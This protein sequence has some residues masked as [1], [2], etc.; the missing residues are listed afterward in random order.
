M[1]PAFSL[2]P[3][4]LGAAALLAGCAT[5]PVGPDY[6]PPE[7]LQPAHAAS[8]GAFASAEAQ[9]ASSATPLPPQWWRLYDDARLD[10]LIEQAFAHNTDLRQAVAN[11]EREQAVDQ[12]VRGAQKP[13]VT[14]GGGPSFGHKSGLDLVKPGYE[15]PSTM[16]YGA[17]ASLSYQL[18][19][20]GQIRRAIEAAE[21]GTGSAEAAVD[22]VRVN[23]AAGTARAYAEACSAGLRLQS[24]NTSIQ[25]QQQAV[26]LSDRLQQAG[27]VGVIDAARAR[28]QLE[29]LRA[30][31]PP[32]Q[33]ARQ[34]ALYRLATLTGAPPR[35]FPQAVAECAA[36]P[37]L[38]GAI[39]VGDGAA[40]LRRRPD[41]RQAERGVA[42]A[43]ARIGVATADLYPKV[44]LGISAISAG[45][46]NDFGSSDTLNYSL[47]PL[48]SW[49]I[50]NTGAAQA[51]IAQAEAGTRSALARFD[52]TVLNALRETETALNV[53]ARELDRHAALKAARDQSAIV[54][55]QARQ[56]Y[57][58]GK[59]GSLDA[60]DAERALAGSEAALAASDAQLSDDQIGVFLALGGGWEQPAAVAA[61]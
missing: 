7:A 19:L 26:T 50:P 32:L 2:A 17:T 22:L 41:I 31:V 20:F 44:S 21:A 59:T 25:L 52:G 48:I 57:R 49:T 5:H 38:A 24:A 42:V 1:K 34:N 45:R 27:K 15:P 54:A 47:G 11:L 14:V 16:N 13:S 4:A 36:P 56:L 23:V 55:D 6:H 53:Y 46:L 61:R 3:L 9:A 39:P 40:L 43:N 58:N 12:E 30:A 10:A 35:E 33:A 60:L 37:R 18:D 28:G 29:Q 51:R 8:A